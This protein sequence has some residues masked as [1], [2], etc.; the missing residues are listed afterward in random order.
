MDC[1]G[2]C[3]MFNG[4]STQPSPTTFDWSVSPGGT[5]CDTFAGQVSASGQFSSTETDCSPAGDGTTFN[6]QID[7]A[8]CSMS[9]TYTYVISGCTVTFT[10]TGTQ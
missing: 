5:L 1:T 7:V 6:G 3:V 10:I 2:D 8:T 9:G 4:T